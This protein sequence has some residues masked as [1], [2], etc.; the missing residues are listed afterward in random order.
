MQEVVADSAARL[1]PYQGFVEALS[2]EHAE[3]WVWNLANAGERVE[4]E[5]FHA[6]TGERL[7]RAVADQHRWGLKEFGIG[8]GRHGFYVRFAAPV[9][10]AVVRVRCAG[11]GS[12][13]PLS[14]QLKREYTPVHFV[15]M[16]IVDNCNLRCPFCVYDY[17]SVHTTH[18]MREA[19]LDAA[20]RFLPY[21]M[22]G[23]FFFSCLHEPALHPK[24][25]PYV[26]KVPAEYR[27]KIFYTTNLAKRMPPVYFEWLDETGMHHLNIS[28]ESLKPELYERMRKGARHRIFMENWDRL[29]PAIRAGKNPPPLRYIAMA[30]K[31]NLRELPDLVA[32][33]LNERAGS[34]IEIRYTFDEAHIPADFKATEFLDAGEW[35]WLRE[36]LRD[37]SPEQVLLSLPPSEDA[38]PAADDAGRFLRGCY[39]FTLSSNA[40]LIVNRAAAGHRADNRVDGKLVETDVR[41]IEDA[42]AF[43]RGLPF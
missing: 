4:L 29:V 9:D 35:E 32:Y 16:D 12:E 40:T 10:A 18:L 37:Y 5:F 19:T 11:D 38:V 36:Q 28:I 3:G 24:L 31:S 7:A 33:L 14:P 23:H 41:T 17:S 15:A 1:G 30:Y 6:R 2:S 8:D 25:M 26:D 34:Q 43:L 27:R 21:V 39:E 13:L 20:L 42:G 22:D